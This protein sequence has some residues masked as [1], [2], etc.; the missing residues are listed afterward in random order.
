MV[1]HGIRSQ[2]RSTIDRGQRRREFHG[3]LQ[4]L[5]EAKHGDTVYVSA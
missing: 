1:S 3:T 5:I 4:W 2:Q